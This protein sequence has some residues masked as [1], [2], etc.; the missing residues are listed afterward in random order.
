MQ[1]RATQQTA[2][3]AYKVTMSIN[4]HMI[5]HSNRVV[6]PELVSHNPLEDHSPFKGNAHKMTMA[7]ALQ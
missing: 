2:A 5:P 1:S 4:A 7:T 3:L 6:V